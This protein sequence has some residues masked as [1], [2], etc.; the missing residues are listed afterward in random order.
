ME[1]IFGYIPNILLNSG[2]E[3]AVYTLTLIGAG[4]LVC[5]VIMLVVSN[6]SKDYSKEVK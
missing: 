1:Y 3:S 2:I 6:L 4:L 5:S